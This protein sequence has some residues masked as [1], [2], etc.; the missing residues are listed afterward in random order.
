LRRAEQI[1][2][3]LERFG[4]QDSL[5][6]ALAIA[7]DGAVGRPHFARYLVAIEVVKDTA[8]AFRK[9]LGAGKAGDVK[10]HWAPLRQIIE[11]IRDSGGT[12][13]LAHPGKYGLTLTRRL[14]LVKEF[15]RLG[16]QGI[17]VISGLQDPTLTLSLAAAAAAHDLLAACGSDF[18]RPGQ[19]W[20]KL[21][22]PLILPPDCRP[23]W[24]AW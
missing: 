20:A 5:A 23:V 18:H 14:A 7:G 13:V 22:M 19:A 12:A 24:D 6:G 16:G 17:E 15:R 10:Q 4:V 21:G 1:A 11:W 9:Y 3:R 8:Q 2:A